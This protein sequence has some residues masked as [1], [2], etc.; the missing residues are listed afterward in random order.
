MF[1]FIKQSWEEVRYKVEWPTYDKIQ[2]YS[3]AVVIGSIFLSIF[4]CIL[5]LVVKYMVNKIYFL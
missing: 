1:A 2:K 4:I 3:K 5:D